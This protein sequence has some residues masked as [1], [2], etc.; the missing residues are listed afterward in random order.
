MKNRCF[1]RSSNPA[2]EKAFFLLADVGY[3]KRHRCW[4]FRWLVA[5]TNRL[6][7]GA[8]GLI[9]EDLLRGY[10]DLRK[11]LRR[12][13]SA[14]DAADIAQSSAEFALRYAQ[15]NDVFSPASLIFRIANHLQIDA[16]RKR[17]R[18]PVDTVDMSTPALET[19]VVCELS[20]ERQHAGRQQIDLLSRVL[21]DLPPRCRE[22]FVLCKLHGLSYEEAAEEMGV[23][24]T[25]IRKHL[26]RAL[27]TCRN[28][29]FS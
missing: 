17:K 26:I 13:L 11:S 15:S 14:E 12:E 16:A 6:R 25:V 18:Y 1:L 3:H 24:I 23:S 19:H 5:A 27:K 22:A 9:V 21:D 7:D 20:P 29:G 8:M 4:R 28:A 2:S 10:M